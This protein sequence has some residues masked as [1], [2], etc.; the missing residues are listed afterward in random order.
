MKIKVRFWV[1]KIQFHHLNINNTT[2][3]KI[4]LNRVEI[5]T[6]NRGGGIC[7]K[8][9]Q[10]LSRGENSLNQRHNL[11]NQEGIIINQ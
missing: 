1:A 5:M 9:N 2:F 7:Y 4:N 11:N 3:R 10:I 8:G 6:I